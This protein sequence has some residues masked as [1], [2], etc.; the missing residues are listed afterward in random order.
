MTPTLG[1]LEEFQSM[2][3]SSI[4][5]K[6]YNSTS[7]KKKSTNAEPQQS[8]HKS[9]S[10]LHLKFDEIS[11]IS[12]LL[13]IIYLY[14]HL[15]SFRFKTSFK[16]PDHWRDLKAHSGNSIMLSWVSVLFLTL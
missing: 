8:P 14:I 16:I 9:L 7:N 11:N 10:K 2:I 13:C 6:E 4:I 5:N 15:N 3:S 12:I 1:P